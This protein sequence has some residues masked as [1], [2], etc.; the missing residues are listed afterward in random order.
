MRKPAAVKTNSKARVFSE[1]HFKDTPVPGTFVQSR[2]KR[3]NP[4]KVQAD[5]VYRS[6]VVL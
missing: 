4:P 2:Y 5:F 6:E 1:M 3:K